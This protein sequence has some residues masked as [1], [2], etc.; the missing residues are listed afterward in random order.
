MPT[1]MIIP[2]HGPG[3]IYRAGAA[4]LSTITSLMAILSRDAMLGIYPFLAY[5]PPFD[6]IHV[7][8]YLQLKLFKI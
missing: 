3:L 7:V 5:F 1:R 4:V 8:L 2:T 6:R